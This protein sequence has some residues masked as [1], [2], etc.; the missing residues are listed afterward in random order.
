MNKIELSLH[1][2]ASYPANKSSIARR[3]PVRGVGENDADYIT[4]PMA[5][6]VRLLDPAY[7]AWTDMLER[8]YS[9]RFHEKQPTYTDVTVCKEWHSF[10]AFRVWWLNNYREGFSLDKD[11]LVVGNR[12]YAPDACIYVPQWLNTFTVDCGAS[13]GELPIGVC[14]H[15]QTGLYNS[16]CRN[17]ITGKRSY[18]GCFTTPEEAHEAWLKCKLSLAEQLKS[19][20]DAIDTRIYNN[21]VTIIKAAE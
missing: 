20:M 4:A 2:E 11:L 8:A 14:L 17:Q 5:N 7:S 15:K 12:E 3:K 13:R 18:P 19:D 9:E 21:V 1:L 10:S 6:G 16:A